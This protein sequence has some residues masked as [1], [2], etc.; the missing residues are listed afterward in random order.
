MCRVRTQD[1]YIGQCCIPLWF[2]SPVSTVRCMVVF[3][4][5]GP[6]RIESWNSVV[7]IVTGL[8]AGRLCIQFLARNFS[9]LSQKSVF[10][11]GPTQPLS[12][13]VSTRT[14]FLTFRG[15]CIMICSYNKSQQD[16]LFLNFILVKDSTCFRQ[17]YCPSSGS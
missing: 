2:T 13:L 11:L 16:A 7:S 12:C 4:P 15:P 8:Q 3:I 17:S 10:S 5:L 1:N 9:S 6:N 14:S